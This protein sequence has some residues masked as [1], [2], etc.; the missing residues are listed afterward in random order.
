MNWL[1]A[2]TETGRFWYLP[3]LPNETKAVANSSDGPVLDGPIIE[4]VNIYIIFIS[5][6]SFW[7]GEYLVDINI[8]NGAFGQLLRERGQF[9]CWDADEKRKGVGGYD[10]KVGVLCV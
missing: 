1:F 5:I 3:D 6:Y 7:G 8:F 4:R 10:G 9:E 2:S